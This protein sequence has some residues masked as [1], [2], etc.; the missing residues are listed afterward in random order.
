MYSEKYTDEIYEYRCSCP[1]PTQ[2]PAPAAFQVFAVTTGSDFCWHTIRRDACSLGLAE[3]T[4]MLPRFHTRCMGWILT[5]SSSDPVLTSGYTA[6]LLEELLVE[7]DG[8][9]RSMLLAV[10]NLLALCLCCCRREAC[11]VSLC[12]HR[13]RLA[14]ECC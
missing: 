2:L 14:V 1:F 7:S 5:C 3:Q 10:C 13:S 12:A 6:C 4:R 8:T 9:Q 11:D